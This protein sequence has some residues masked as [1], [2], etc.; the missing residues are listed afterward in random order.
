M[1]TDFKITVRRNTHPNIG[2]DMG[3]V[4]DVEDLT[5]HE[6]ATFDTRKEADCW[7][8]K[9]HTNNLLKLLK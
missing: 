4:F 5:T 8:R 7:M 2:Y 9:Q 3:S 1:K 6:T